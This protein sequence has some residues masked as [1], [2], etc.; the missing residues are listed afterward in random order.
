MATAAASAAPTVAATVTVAASATP[1]ASSTP[2]PSASA[3]PIAATVKPS[4]TPTPA[5]AS[6]APTPSAKPQ[7]ADD[8]ATSTAAQAQVLYKDNCMACHGEGLTGDFG[9]NLTKVGSRKTKDE[10]AAQII[11]GKGDMPPFQ[12]T[13]K[14]AEIEA[15]A[16]WL[17]TKK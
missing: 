16:A 8:G 15:L 17:A 9:P 6:A 7:A 1:A 3:A 2:Q 5:P 4:P 10:I 12:S 14:S 13:L 11:N